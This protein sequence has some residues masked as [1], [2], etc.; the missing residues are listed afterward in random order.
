VFRVSNSSSKTR[1]HGPRTPCGT[2]CVVPR[3]GVT[4]S[5]SAPARVSAPLSAGGGASVG[6]SAPL[7]GG[8][9][10]TGMSAPGTLEAAGSTAADSGGVFPESV[11][12]C[13]MGNAAGSALPDNTTK[14]RRQHSQC[15]ERPVMEERRPG[16][17]TE[18]CRCCGPLSAGAHPV[19]PDAVWAGCTLVLP[20]TNSAGSLTLFFRFTL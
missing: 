19:A 2:R 15:F 16:A 17:G 12:G 3:T 20:F 11:D 7:P 10:S 9:D 1:F 4:V 5:E 13:G 6:T 14:M 18:C 8:G